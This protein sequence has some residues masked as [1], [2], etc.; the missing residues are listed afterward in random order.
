M[1]KQEIINKFVSLRWEMGSVPSLLELIQ[2]TDVTVDDLL[3]N[4]PAANVID[5]FVKMANECIKQW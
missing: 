2:N 4:F 5:A 3:A 1:T